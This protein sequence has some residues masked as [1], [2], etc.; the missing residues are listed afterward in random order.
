MASIKLLPRRKVRVRGFGLFQVP[1]HIQRI[2]IDEP[3]KAGTHG[4][5]VRW[6][7]TKFF[8]DAAEGKRDAAGSL[9]RSERYLQSIYTGPRPR[10]RETEHKDKKHR[11]GIAG[12]QLAHRRRKDRQIAEVYLRVNPPMQGGVPRSIYVGTENTITQARMR[13]ALKKARAMRDAMRDAYLEALAKGG[14]ARKKSVVAKKKAPAKKAP[15]KK[16]PA[17]KK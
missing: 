1:R 17:R 3:G 9:A 10:L 5:Q 13:A 2:D 8:S 11:T 4:W 16:A 15:A 14:R 6:D 12:V 7:G